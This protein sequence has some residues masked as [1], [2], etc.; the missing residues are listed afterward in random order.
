MLGEDGKMELQV[1]QAD[2]GCLMEGSFTKQSNEAIWKMGN[3][4]PKSGPKL[5]MS[6]HQYL[7]CQT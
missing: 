5:L 7:S 6:V 4:F 2:R 1:G 3:S